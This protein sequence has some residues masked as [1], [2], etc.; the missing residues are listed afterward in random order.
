MKISKYVSYDE[1]FLLNTFVEEKYYPWKR[2]FDNSVYLLILN[3]FQIIDAFSGPAS[4][5][6][7]CQS[8]CLFRVSR[9]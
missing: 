3:S 8:A 4:V 5:K 9:E 6:K 2:Y 1:S 7:D